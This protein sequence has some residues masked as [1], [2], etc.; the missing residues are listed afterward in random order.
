MSKVTSKGICILGATG[1]IGVN[2]LD[3]IARHP[4]NYH[5]VALSANK[6]VEKLEQQCL[7]FKPQYAVM[8]DEN[9]AEKL[10]KRLKK[11]GNETKILSGK[12]AL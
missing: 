10:E 9:A 1:T 2:T 12:K 3:V 4:N 6:N 11:A 5:V 7:E 8:V